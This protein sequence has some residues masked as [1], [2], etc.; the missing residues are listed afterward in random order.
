MDLLD[1]NG[2]P[3][4]SVSMY[5][6]ICEMI[7]DKNEVEVAGGGG[8]EVDL[9][10]DVEIDVSSLTRS[11][12]DGDDTSTYVDT[13]ETFDI[14]QS[15]P[16]NNEVFQLSP[17]SE[18]NLSIP[19]QQLSAPS[20]QCQPSAT[21]NVFKDQSTKKSC[22]SLQRSP[23][24]CGECGKIFHYRGYLTVHKRMHSGEK[25]FKCQ[26]SPSNTNQTS[27]L[28]LTYRGVFIIN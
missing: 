22:S 23:D 27:Y 6:N 14:K 20:I 8:E 13:V 16:Q 4:S 10:N 19:E 18:N 3:P 2:A 26:V 15:K 1:T 5:E 12:I 7:L 21:S 28:L 24:Q 17:G 25:P 9:L 11:D